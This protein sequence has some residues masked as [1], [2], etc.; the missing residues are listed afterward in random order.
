M[1]EIRI[2]A[3]NQEKMS[4]LLERARTDAAFRARLA[5]NPQ[6]V[7]REYG[8]EHLIAGQPVNVA[9]DIGAHHQVG[10]MRSTDSQIIDAIHID[11]NLPHADTDEHGDTNNPHSDSQVHVD[12]GG[13]ADTPE[14]IDRPPMHVDHWDVTRSG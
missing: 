13:H 4:A 12:T 3:E 14:H 6:V 2:T 11:A 10:V 7:L 5:A 8:L 1:P 9:L